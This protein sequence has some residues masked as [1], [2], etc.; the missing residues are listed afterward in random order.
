MFNKKCKRIAAIALVLTAVF[1]FT[2]CSLLINMDLVPVESFVPQSTAKAVL[3]KSSVQS[4]YPHPCFDPEDGEDDLVRPLE[5][6]Q[7]KKEEVA[8]DEAALLDVAMKFRLPRFPEG[9]KLR[10][11]Y[12]AAIEALNAI[13]KK[14]MTDTD[15]VHAIYDYLVYYVDY[16]FELYKRYQEDPKKVSAGERAFKLEGVFLD[17]TAVCD[18][19][20]KAF[21]L[22]CS[23]ECIPNVRIVGDKD[24]I[25]HAWNKVLID[26]QW[27]LVDATWGNFALNSGEEGE[28]II[29]EFLSHAYFLTTDDSTYVEK[30]IYSAGNYTLEQVKAD[31]D[32]G[33]HE[34]AGLPEVKEIIPDLEISDLVIPKGEFMSM[35]D[36]AI[37][38]YSEINNLE[39][40]STIFYCGKNYYLMIKTE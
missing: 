38:F 27:Y 4:E 20:S 26:G 25:P 19:I 24:G 10:A 39:D 23:I 30:K 6:L 28:E 9:S 7:E 32:F 5:N 1:L 17:K 37:E 40:N 2:S 3:E 34:K 29:T 15:K 21:S 11:V 33:Y 12:N 13:I 8:R 16:D 31:E 36:T 14:E 18:G 35:P 22:M